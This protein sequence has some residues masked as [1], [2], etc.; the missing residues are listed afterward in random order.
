MGFIDQLNRLTK[1]P[2]TAVD[3]P[4]AAPEPRASDRKPDPPR[5]G[6]P[7]GAPNTVESWQ[8]DREWITNW[9]APSNVVA[10][11]ALRQP[12]IRRA[13]GKRGRCLVPVD[14]ILRREPSNAH[15]ENAVIAL[16]G[17]AHVGYLRAE[18]AAAAA[19]LLLTWSGP[20]IW[21]IAGLIRG[22][23]EGY[24][25]GVHLWL[26]RRV[27][28]CPEIEFDADQWAVSW[29]PGPLELEECGLS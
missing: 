6:D 9:D 23:G 15:D 19:P 13:A 18:I 4:A 7:A 16:V 12:A 29:P 25:L 27:S 5:A 2:P 26:G 14:V 11:E 24:P 28:P 21:V 8:A 3:I 20:R 22:G 1:A 10:G 17:G